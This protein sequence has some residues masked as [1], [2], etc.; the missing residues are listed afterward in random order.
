MIKH[1]VGNKFD[2]KIECIFSSK[3]RK[4][5]EGDFEMQV[6]WQMQVIKHNAQLLVCGC[7]EKGRR[8]TVSLSSVLMSQRKH[9]ND[10]TAL[11]SLQW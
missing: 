5:R 1:H 4:C 11:S 8:V 10:V 3:P 7:S 9:V 6:I 2:L